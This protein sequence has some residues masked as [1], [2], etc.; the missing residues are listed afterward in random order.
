MVNATW[1]GEDLATL[2]TMLGEGSLRSIIHREVGLTEVPAAIAE[3]EGGH[4]PGK[5]VVRP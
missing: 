3:L 1:S 4:V 5:I 2:A